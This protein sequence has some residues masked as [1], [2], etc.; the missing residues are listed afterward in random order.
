M[1][2]IFSKNLCYYLF[3]PDIEQITSRIISKYFSK[4][5]RRNLFKKY[6]FTIIFYII[7]RRKA[8]NGQ[9]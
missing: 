9:G 8:N 3:Y 5:E 2:D 4:S 1:E 7:K 6:I